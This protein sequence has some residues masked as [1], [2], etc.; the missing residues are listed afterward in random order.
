MGGV[1]LLT[2]LAARYSPRANEI[3]LDGV[4]L[5]FT[6][7]LATAIA[8][9]L[10]FLASIPRDGTFAAWIQAG[11]H[12]L[13]GSFRKSRLQRALVVVQ[14]AVS[15]MSPERA[16]LFQAGGALAVALS[17]FLWWLRFRP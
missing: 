2:A 10:S 3:G 8:L 9:L 4:V 15:V 11:A 14:V 1:R 12:R 7:A 5:A 13:S 16:W 6:V 17:A